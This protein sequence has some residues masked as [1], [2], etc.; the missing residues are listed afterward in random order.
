VAAVGGESLSKVNAATPTPTA[1][2]MVAP[3]A[4]VRTSAVPHPG[5]ARRPVLGKDVVSVGEHRVEPRGSYRKGA[6]V[7]SIAY[8]LLKS[9]SEVLC[10]NCTYLIWI[11]LVEVAAQTS[12]LCPVC[13]DRIW[14]IDDRGSVANAGD[15]IQGAFSDLAD[16]LQ[17]A[18]K[19]LFS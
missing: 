6:R 17:K 8:E 19:G 13:R 16:D 10:P 11:R 18:M 4:S 7:A 3:S 12:V 2:A 14:L 5:G 9:D 1:M 15:Q